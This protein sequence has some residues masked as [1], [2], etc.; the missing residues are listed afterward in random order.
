LTPTD[1]DQTN[2]PSFIF[3][4]KTDE[5]APKS[6]KGEPA[7]HTARALAMARS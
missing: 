7:S 1:L 4:F 5:Y 6:K 3:I 2:A